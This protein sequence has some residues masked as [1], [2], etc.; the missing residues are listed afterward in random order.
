MSK[1]SLKSNLKGLSIGALLSLALSLGV[2]GVAVGQKGQS[3]WGPS[4]WGSGAPQ[5][6]GGSASKTDNAT[7][8]KK[9]ENKTSNATK[10]DKKTR[11]KSGW[12]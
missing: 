8:D 11:G 5:R 4:G 7:K 2:P 10:D 9:T 6:S 3:G 1:E 12:G